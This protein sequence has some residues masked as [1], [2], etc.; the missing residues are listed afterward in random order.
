MIGSLNLRQN[1]KVIIP[2]PSSELFQPMCCNDETVKP[3]MSNPMRMRFRWWLVS[4]IWGD[5]MLLIT[6]SLIIY[7]RPVGKIYETYDPLSQRRPDASPYHTTRSANGGYIPVLM[8]YNYWQLLLQGNLSVLLK[9]I[10]PI[11]SKVIDNYQ[12]YCTC[13]ST[14]PPLRFQECALKPVDRRP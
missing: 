9:T 10:L 3:S 7:T 8:S 14:A 1:K 2:W 6:Q 4:S 5:K 12:S 13:R 11:H